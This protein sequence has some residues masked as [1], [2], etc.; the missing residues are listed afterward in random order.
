MLPQQKNYS[1]VTKGFTTA[2]SS[3]GSWGCPAA[4]GKA[5]EAKAHGAS[6]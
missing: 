4:R 3:T 5:A 2:S 6:P 1:F